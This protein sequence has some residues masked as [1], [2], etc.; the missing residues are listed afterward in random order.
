MSAKRK[1]KLSG[2]KRGPYTSRIERPL[3]PQNPCAV[4]MLR[5]LALSGWRSGE[6]KAL[7]WSDVDLARGV[8]TLPDTKTGRSVRPLGSAALGVLK[9]LGQRDDYSAGN[10]FVFPGAKPAAPL[11]EIDHVW[12]AV[13]H[14]AGLDI[15]LHGL[16]HA[17]TTTAR[18][19]GYGDHVIARLIGH[20][21][22]DSQTSRYGDV[23]ELQ[24]REAAEKVSRQI[25][26]M[27]DPTPSRVLPFPAVVA[28]A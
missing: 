14:A 7:R 20:V 27:L 12:A 6:A 1:A 13:R 15:T 4:A 3:A 8:A 22:N 11:V 23:P 18:W 16:R 21:L 24:V 2:R 28:D 5:F 25:A 9:E 19:L 10:P 17:F 26:S